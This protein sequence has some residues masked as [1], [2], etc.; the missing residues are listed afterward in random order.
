MME[1]KRRKVGLRNCERQIRKICKRRE[2]ERERLEASEE[3][4]MYEQPVSRYM[5]SWKLLEE[6]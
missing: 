2:R 6:H 3:F 5:E 4:F 1:L